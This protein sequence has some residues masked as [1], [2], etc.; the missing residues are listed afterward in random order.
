MISDLLIRFL[1]LVRLLVELD[2]NVLAS[3]SAYDEF[4][5]HFSPSR[6]DTC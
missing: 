1:M 4:R 3:C 2:K 5:K 6:S